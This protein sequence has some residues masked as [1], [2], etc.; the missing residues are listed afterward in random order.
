M[1]TTLYTYFRSSASYRVRIGLGL[2]GLDP[3]STGFEGVK[4]LMIE[5]ITSAANG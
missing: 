5:P 3:S 2:K 1:D 4:D